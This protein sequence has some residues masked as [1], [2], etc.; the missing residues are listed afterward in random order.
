MS[1]RIATLTRVLGFLLGGFFAVSLAVL[2]FI[3]V[4]F[5]SSRVSTTLSQY[6][7]DQYQRSLRIG[8]APAC[9]CGRCRC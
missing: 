1:L 8:E 5:D 6:F 7:R 4:S 3:W 2:L 9:G